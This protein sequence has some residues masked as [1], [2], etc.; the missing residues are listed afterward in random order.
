MAN[1]VA[2]TERRKVSWYISLIILILTATLFLCYLLA[3]VLWCLARRNRS[4]MEC[5]GCF[6]RKDH[7]WK[8]LLLKKKLFPCSYNKMNSF[9]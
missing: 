2:I 4:R 7:G 5:A 1:I 8:T 3:L 6:T 9:V